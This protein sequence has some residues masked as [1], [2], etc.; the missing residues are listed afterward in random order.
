MVF[1]YGKF[2]T[3]GNTVKDG[4]IEQIMYD[5]ALSPSFDAIIIARKPYKGSCV[6]NVI[7]WGVG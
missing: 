1:V 3:G 4:E 2:N 5:I 7:N 6:D